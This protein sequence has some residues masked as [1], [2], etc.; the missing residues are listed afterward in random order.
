MIR[1]RHA[2][3]AFHT[4]K[5]SQRK[6]G[7]LKKLSGSKDR[8]TGIQVCKTRD[9]MTSLTYMGTSSPLGPTMAV[10][11]DAALEST[12][13]ILFSAV[14]LQP[15]A[16]LTSFPFRR[17]KAG[18]RASRIGGSSLNTLIGNFGSRHLAEGLCQRM[19]VHPDVRL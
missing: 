7:L 16:I 13:A 2:P 6:I 4:V 8:E 3:G 19:T 17:C 9:E 11:V 1:L 12:A 5:H 15:K 14:D 18:R 10:D